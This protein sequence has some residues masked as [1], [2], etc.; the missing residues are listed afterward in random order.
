MIRSMGSKK[1]VTIDVFLPSERTARIQEAGRVAA[2]IDALP[3]SIY[4]G[5]LSTLVQQACLESFFVHVRGLLEF[6]RVKESDASRDFSAADILESWAPQTEQSQRNK[7]IGYWKVASS[8][9]MHFSHGRVR[10]DGKPD[11][12]VDTSYEALQAIADDVLEVWDD[13]AK[14]LNHPLAPVRSEFSLFTVN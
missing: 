13:F 4:G 3:G 8:Q 10:R 5:N 6:L 7:L 1:P 9:L 11:V 12:E 2:M 14:Q